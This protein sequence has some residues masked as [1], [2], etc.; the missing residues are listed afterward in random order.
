M[1][2]TEIYNMQGIRVLTVDGYPETDTLPL[3][4][5]CYIMHLRHTDGTLTTEKTVL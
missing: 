2:T 4:P 5:G 3:S 1:L